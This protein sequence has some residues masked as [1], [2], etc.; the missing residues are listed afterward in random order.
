[1]EEKTGM[2]LREQ[3]PSEPPHGPQ[4]PRRGWGRLL[5]LPER[6]QIPE[7]GVPP[8]PEEAAEYNAG[9]HPSR[10]AAFVKSRI[11]KDTAA[12]M[13]TLAGFGAVAVYDPP[14][15][16]GV[17]EAGE[18]VA[19]K[20]LIQNGFLSNPNMFNNQN[21]YGKLS[22]NNSVGVPLDELVGKTGIENGKKITVGSLFDLSRTGNIRYV[23]GLPYDGSGGLSEYEKYRNQGIKNTIAFTDI[24][25]GTVVYAPFKGKVAR[26]IGQY[27]DTYLGMGMVFTDDE[28]KW[29]SLS[30]SGARNVKMITEVPKLDS[31]TSYGSLDK[32]V[33]VDIGDPLFEITSAELVGSPNA[34]GFSSP[35]QLRVEVN[36][37]PNGFGKDPW[38]PI[39]IDFATKEGKLAYVNSQ[40]V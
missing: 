18:I 35:S 6:P 37:G 38:I 36:Y 25:I 11:G 24:P 4:P 9:Q 22:Q 39:N 23:K 7:H 8:T 1:M 17:I 30:F 32:W 21:N 26:S 15:I 16:P 28:G 19:N 31:R 33:D 10:L 2:A 5:H 29:Y 13:G 3:R 27:A 40:G 14:L 20:L 12:A 34:I